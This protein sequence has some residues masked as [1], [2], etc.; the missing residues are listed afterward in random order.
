[1]ELENIA[2]I[3][4][5]EIDKVGPKGDSAYEVYLK[6]GGTLSEKEWL[7]SLKGEQGEKG[8]KGDTGSVKFLIVSELPTENIDSTAIYMKPC[9]QPNSDNT[10]EE[11]IYVNDKWELLGTI[12]TN[13]DMTDYYTKKEI[14]VSKQDKLIPGDGIEIG[15]DNIISASIEIPSGTIFINAKN[16]ADFIS[17]KNVEIFRNWYN[18]YRNGE[19]SPIYVL[20]INR[21]VSFTKYK[22]CQLSDVRDETD[23]KRLYLY[24][25]YREYNNLKVDME[26]N[27]IYQFSMYINY[28]SDNNVVS[29]HTDNNNSYLKFKQ[30]KM[31]LSSDLSYY[32]SKTNT[33]V[34]TPTNDY[35]PATK[36]YVDDIPTT[37]TGYDATKTQVLKNINGTLTWVNEE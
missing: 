2:E 5:D 9:E 32:L 8:E 31:A 11:Y 22:L 28:D 18:D 14:D 12:S 35:N 1:M 36:K 19:Y 10:Y 24:F 25:T 21:D 6:N 33:T 17:D 37:Y 30:Y 27:N 23:Y 15:E 7:E 34:Y 4:I 16:Y 3:E 26:P 29:I 13:V 20:T